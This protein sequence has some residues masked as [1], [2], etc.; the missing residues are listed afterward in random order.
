MTL[1]FSTLVLLFMMVLLTLAIVSTVLGVAGFAGWW[2]VARGKGR[3]PWPLFYGL[4]Q[5]IFDQLRRRSL[6]AEMWK[7]YTWEFPSR[8]GFGN[9]MPGSRFFME[10]PINKQR[11]IQYQQRPRELNPHEFDTYV[12]L[13]IP[14]IEALVA[15]LRQLAQAQHYSAYDQ[16]CNTLAFVQQTIC[17]TEDLS[18]LT[19]QL[20]EYPKYPL[21]TLVEKKGDC[22]D[23]SILA[24]AL[25]AALDYQVALLILPVHVALGV[26]GFDDKPGSRVIHPAT[27]VRY[28][29]AETTAPNWLPGE[30]P[31]QFRSYLASGQFE[32][33]PVEIKQDLENPTSFALQNR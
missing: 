25:L 17:F 20:I 32:I 11:Y 3:L 6:A 28:L 16:L 8:P 2:L 27:G 23:Q 1:T 14:E 7:W 10:L 22:E 19:G 15:Q 13:S 9:R 33:L 30:V 24:A 31:S 18:P 26:A 4:M 21:E 5:Q 12:T 29:Y